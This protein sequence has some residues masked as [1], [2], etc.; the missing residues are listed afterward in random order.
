MFA[1]T[2][3]SSATRVCDLSELPVSAPTSTAISSAVSV[4][5]DDN[6]VVHTTLNETIA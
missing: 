4:K 2:S 1:D 3:N 6:E 5:A